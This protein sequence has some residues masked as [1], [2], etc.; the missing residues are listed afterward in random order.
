VLSDDGHLSNEQ[1]TALVRAVLARS[2]AGRLRHLVQ[3]HLSRECNRPSLARGG[4]RALLAEL[5]INATVHTAD[6]HVP[7]TPLDL[8]TPVSK[9]SKNQSRNGRER[10]SAAAQPLL[11]GLE[12]SL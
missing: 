7:G 9:R 2:P 8:R 1:A 11:P 3:L 6:Q 5:D 12:E 10:R 4:L